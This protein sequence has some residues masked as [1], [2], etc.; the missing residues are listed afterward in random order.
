MGEQHARAQCGLRKSLSS[1]RK[2]EVSPTQHQTEI[3]GEG[4]S[5]VRLKLDDWEE[6]EACPADEG[7]GFT[8]CALHRA[9]S[10]IA[11]AHS[12]QDNGDLNEMKSS[13]SSRVI[14]MFVRVSLRNQFSLNIP[15]LSHPHQ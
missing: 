12:A 6:R 15:R 14:L 13:N 7:E 8:E 2:L 3:E 11:Q 5:R 4:N 10:S 1:C 9:P